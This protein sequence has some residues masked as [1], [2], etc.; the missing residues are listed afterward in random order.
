MILRK[1]SEEDGN[2]STPLNHE[3]SLVLCSITAQ[4]YI[5]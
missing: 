5:V 3:Y 4:S 1:V 2:A